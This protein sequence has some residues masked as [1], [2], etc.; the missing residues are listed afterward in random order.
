MTK[1]R[2]AKACEITP[3]TTIE[4]NIDDI[5]SKM[6]VDEIRV[7]ADGPE[8]FFNTAAGGCLMMT[9]DHPVKILKHAQPQEPTYFGAVVTFGALRAV[10]LYDDYPD[11]TTRQ[12][13][14]YT[15]HQSSLGF[16]TWDELVEKADDYDDTIETINVYKFDC[17]TR[18]DT[19]PKKQQDHRPGPV[20]GLI[21]M[22]PHEL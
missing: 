13:I 1:P 10:R 12:W 18:R 16:Y 8:L 9:P 3:G 5:T 20:I 11:T 15:A 7:H 21:R 2:E 17:Q 6:L 4:F 22:Q 14:L 19:R